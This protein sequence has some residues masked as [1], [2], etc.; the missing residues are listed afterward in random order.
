MPASPTVFLFPGQSSRQPGLIE[1]AVSLWP[2]V[3]LPLVEC[4][5]QVLG[6]DL[7]G[8]YRAVGDAPFSGNVHVQVGVFLANHLRLAVLEARGIEAALSLGLSLGEYNHLVHI[9]VVTFEDALRLVDA[10]GRAYDDGPA[11]AMAAVF[12]IELP[13]LMPILERARQRGVIEIGSFNSPTQYVLSGERTAIDA[14]L[15]ILEDE[16]F[17]A[18]RIIEDRIPMHCSR[19]AR[20]AQVFRP[21]LE[22]APW[23]DARLPYIPNVEAVPLESPSPLQ[24]VDL[25][26]RH[27]DHP[28]YWWQSIDRIAAD[29][30]DAAF[31]EVGPGRVLYDLLRRTS[32]PHPRFKTETAADSDAVTAAF[33]SSEGVR[34][35]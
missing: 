12:P 28:V 5:S 33:A 18:G 6:R 3:T 21:V 32:H 14:A 8:H 1:A 2:E 34:E 27:V 15:A 13:V 11:G 24:I 30:E 29:H 10:R 35:R 16:E 4:A 26:A 23:L 7:R 19:F 9:G 17:I 31:V 20:V 22:R 25:L